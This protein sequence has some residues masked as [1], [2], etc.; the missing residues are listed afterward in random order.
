MKSK[1]EKLH[2]LDPAEDQV[3]GRRLRLLTEVG[4]GQKLE[5]P[6]QA[7]ETALLGDKAAESGTA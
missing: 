1:A 4:A 7:E 2:D 3:P 6:S 5:P